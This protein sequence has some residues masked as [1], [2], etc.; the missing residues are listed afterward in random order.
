MKESWEVHMRGSR[1]KERKQGKWYNCIVISKIKEIIK[2]DAIKWSKRDHFHIPDYLL[3]VY[4][5]IGPDNDNI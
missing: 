2:K 1:G 3:Y 5:E 4:N